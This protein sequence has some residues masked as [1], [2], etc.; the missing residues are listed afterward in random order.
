[1][2]CTKLKWN[3]L[4]FYSKF[5]LQYFS[6]LCVFNDIKGK[7]I[8]DSKRLS[9][10]SDWLGAERARDRSSSPDRVN[11]LHFYI[12]STPALGPTHPPIQRV[13]WALSPGVKRQVRKADHS[14]PNSVEDKE[15][16]IF[17]PT[18]PY[19]LMA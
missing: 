10:Y 13:P 7:V 5:H 17:T 14:P 18:P 9:Q 19:F 16:W 12:S 15:M 8:Y 1:M 3:S 11:N 4:S 6:V 2:L